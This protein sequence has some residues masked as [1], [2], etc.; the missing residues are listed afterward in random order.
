MAAKL[1]TFDHISAP[2]ARRDLILVSIPMFL[3]SKNPK[4]TTSL[5]FD[6]VGAAILNFK[7]AAMKFIF[8]L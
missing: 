8:L 2:E 3:G 5:D 7:M 4:N 1:I 6:T